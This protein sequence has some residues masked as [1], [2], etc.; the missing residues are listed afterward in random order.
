MAQDSHEKKTIGY[1]EKEG[2]E[3]EE[4]KTLLANRVHDIIT[5]CYSC[6][7]SCDCFIYCRSSSRE[8][9]GCKFTYFTVTEM[10]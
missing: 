6:Y 3:K 9:L 7:I 5:E 4:Y 1:S 2:Q 8:V 10:L